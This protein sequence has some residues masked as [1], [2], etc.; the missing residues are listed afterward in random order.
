MDPRQRALDRRFFRAISLWLVI[1]V[2]LLGIAVGLDL[3][4]V[5][6][7]RHDCYRCGEAGALYPLGGFFVLTGVGALVRRWRRGPDE[8]GEHSRY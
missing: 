1:G 5:Q 4:G 2:V 8:P 6:M 3:A 7:W